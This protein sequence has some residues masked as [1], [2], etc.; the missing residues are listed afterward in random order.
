MF[1]AAIDASAEV[2]ERGGKRIG[3]V[4][5]RSYANSDYHEKLKELLRTK[6]KDAD[7]LVIDIRGGWG[8]A[9]P[10]YMDIFNPVAPV[11]THARR[12]GE[13]SE[14]APTWRKPVAL[15]ID[16]GTR[17]GKEMLSY[18]FKTH[19]LGVLVGERTAGAVLGGTARPL[20][21]GS[22]LFVAVTDVRID[23]VKLEGEGVA[24]D[25]EVKRNLPYS[26]GADEQRDV[27]IDAMV[28]AA[29]R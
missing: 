7:A 28:K 21:D 24:P 2:V 26:K 8:G 14:V 12:D 6:L 27:A 4:R 22:L 9:S 5:I 15:L 10:Q 11:L 29:T 3:Y 1:L 16:H 19:K 18:A 23:G 25:I 17:S 13:R 20:S